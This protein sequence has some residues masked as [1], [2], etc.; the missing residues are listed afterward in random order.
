MDSKN[1]RRRA[2]RRS[3][4][5]PILLCI[6]GILTAIFMAT[7]VRIVRAEKVMAVSEPP[8]E[9][10]AAATAPSE[11]TQPKTTEVTEATEATRPQLSFQ[12]A[13]EGYFADALFI[14]DSRTVGLSEYGGLPEATF[15]AD[16]GM[17]VYNIDDK[18]VSVPEVG[19][20]SFDGLLQQVSYGKI[21]LMLGIN[22]LGYD[23]AETVRQYGALLERIQAAQPQAVIFIMANLHVSAQ[24]SQ[25]DDLYNNRNI[26][27]FN[28][29]IQPLADDKTVFYLDVNEL[30]DDENGNLREDYT[31][32]NAHLLGV[33]YTDWGNWLATKAVVA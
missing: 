10:S 23:R 19:T 15:F 6:V 32:D 11:E 13:P 28:R 21:Y 30:F 20:V 16:S 24:Q 9:P 14:G 25:R 8:S 27:E 22:E 17:S 4:E 5:E 18:T 3:P 31:A 1:K 29:R 26:D 7:G 33:Y 12:D 2:R